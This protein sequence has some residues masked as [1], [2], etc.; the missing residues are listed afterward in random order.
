MKTKA[1]SERELASELGA[2]RAAWDGIVAALTE[3]FGT[4]DVEWKPSK[5]A[6]GRM[7]LLKLKKRTLL[8][9]MPDG[10]KFQVA[11]VLGERAVGL[12][13]AARLPARIKKLIREAHPYVEGRGIRFPV[14]STRDV[15]MIAQL[16][17]IKI[18]PK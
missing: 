10:G 12:A 4:M 8:Y 3:R 11:I 15:P 9:L 5:L 14:A 13:L 17:E 7:C 6:F 2:A 1:P 18:T 16:V